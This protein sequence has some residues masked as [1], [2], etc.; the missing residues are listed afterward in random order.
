MLGEAGLWGCFLMA[1]DVFCCCSFKNEAHL[2]QRL[3]RFMASQLALVCWAQ[4]GHC[5][6]QV[7]GLAPPSPILAGAEALCKGSLSAP[8]LAPLG[9]A[10][11]EL[12]QPITIFMGSH[13]QK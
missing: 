2:G 9:S 3:L 10:V 12:H 4:L 13:K 5:L 6:L 11:F 1:A 7:S 8:E